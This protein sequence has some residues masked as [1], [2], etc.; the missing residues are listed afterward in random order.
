MKVLYSWLK[1]FYKVPESPE[2]LAELL[3]FSSFETI[4]DK[5][6]K[7]DAVL[8]ISL[9]ANRVADATS[10]FGIAREIALLKGKEINLKDALPPEGKEKIQNF[11]KVKVTAPKLVRRYTLR[12]IKNVK[13][14]ESPAWLKKGLEACGIRPINNIVDAANYV[15]LE[16]GQPLH[17]F[18][19][20]EV[21]DRTVIVRQAKKGEKIETIERKTYI[22]DGFELLITDKKGPLGFAGIKGGR[23]GEITS[24]TKNILIE[25]ANF[26]PTLT[27]E[28][29]K[30]HGLRTDASW[31]FENNLDPNLAEAAVNRVAGLIHELAGGE[32]FQNLI[33]F[34]P[35]KVLPVPI[36]VDVEKLSKLLGIP[37][38]EKRVMD[39]VKPFCSWIE[40]IH[41]RKS[42]LLLHIKT[43]RRDLCYPEDIAEEVARLIG[44]NNIPAKAPVLELR[45]R[46]KNESLEFRE[47]LKDHMVALGF[48]EVYNYSF[49]SERDAKAL[50][51]DRNKLLEIANPISGET[52]YLR[53]SLLPNLLKNI[54]DNFR[55][56]DEVRIFEIGKHYRGKDRRPMEAWWMAGVI[57][58]KTIKSVDLFFDAKGLMESLL[59]RLGFDREDYRWKEP[60]YRHQNMLPTAVAT[61]FVDNTDIAMVGIVRPN[62]ASKYDIDTPIVYWRL[63]V[64]PLRQAVQGEHEFQPLHKYPDVT[65]DISMLVPIDRKIDTLE[66]IISEASKKYLEE[67]ELFDIYEGEELGKGVKSLAFHLIFRAL[68]RTLTSEE[69]DKEM[70][71]I[72]KRLK[73]AG[74]EIR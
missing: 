13:I 63:D 74:S 65:R 20:D 67:V 39:L 19:A 6:L 7:D 8:E 42:A 31:R 43:F 12:A 37:L 17:A 71:K 30:R 54:R 47:I 4:V 66:Q 41:P 46:V 11:A 14:K 34:Y 50:A 26:D 23:R 70:E 28:A 53:A 1:D 35:K 10:H 40:Q 48:S 38:T 27:R 49:I 55:F 16:V 9:L 45:P 18:D 15:M 25:S 33:D 21:K 64:E 73:E 59:E 72:I 62:V 58:G 24:K 36:L 22:L 44:Y 32:I 68:D 69:V 56:F 51:F 61:L 2:K 52:R 29:S 57:G 60:P 3:S 5:H